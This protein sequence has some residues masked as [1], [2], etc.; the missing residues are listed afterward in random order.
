MET[1]IFLGTILIVVNIYYNGHL[2][3]LF[4]QNKKYL[5]IAFFLLLG[6][7]LYLML[8]RDPVQTRRVLFHAN[9]LVKHLPIERANM[10]Q[11]SPVLDFTHPRK[12]RGER[13]D[14]EDTDR[15]GG[16]HFMQEF[17]SYLTSVGDAVRGTDNLPPLPES[18]TSPKSQ[19]VLDKRVLNPTRGNKRSVSETKKKFVA[20]NQN[21]ACGSCNQMLNAWFEVDH[22]RRLDQGGTNDVSNLVALC[23]ECHGRKTAMENF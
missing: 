12:S 19:A 23:R 6:F 14:T 11:W 15:L 21:W 18:T 3:T 1:I 13:D 22:K 2:E 10:D 7:S 20:A 16:S 4:W 9:N 8:K 5:Q 17:Q